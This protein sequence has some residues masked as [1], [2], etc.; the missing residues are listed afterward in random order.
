MKKRAGT[1]LTCLIGA[2]ALQAAEPVATNPV[3][4]HVVLTWE[5]FKNITDW[6]AHQPDSNANGEFTIPWSEAK[7]LFGIEVENMDAAELTLPWKEFKALLEW[8]VR[9]EERKQQEA[10]NTLPAPT[11]YLITSAE[12]TG[13]ELSDEGAFFEATLKIDILQEDRW[14]KIHV[15]PGNVAISKAELPEG[16]FLQQEGNNYYLLTQATG[17][18]EARFEFTA[19]VSESGGSHSLSFNKVSSGT[20]LV[21]VTVPEKDVDIKIRGAQSKLSKSAGEATRSVAALPANASVYIS[22]ERAIPEADQVPPKLYAETRTLISVNDGMLL[23]RSQLAFNVLHAGTRQIELNIPKGA[24]VYDVRGPSIRDWRID[25]NDLQ[26]HFSREM[27]GSFSVEVLYEAP[28]GTDGAALPVITADGVEREKGHIAIV[29]LS[30][31]EISGLETSGATEVDTKDLPPELLGMT[32]QPVLLGYRYVDPR[33]NVSLK[34]DKHPDV[35]VLL[36][37]VDSAN[38][39]VMQTLDGRRIVKARYNVRNNRNQFLRLKLP[40]GAALWSA[41]VAG[42]TTPPAKDEEGRLLLPLV[43]SQGVGGLSS[44]P[45]EITYAENDQAPDN[46]GRGT[47][48]VA[49]VACEEPVLHMMLELYVPE[50]GRYSDFEGNLREVELFTPIGN[51]ALQLNVA[52]IQRYPQDFDAEVGQRTQAIVRPATDDAVKVQ[53]PVTGELYRFEKI[54]VL[55][56]QPWI[57]YSYT[58]LK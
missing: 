54:L 38:F 1:L 51:E 37:V 31:V 39:T 44:F 57:S 34:I 20:C 14:Q 45:V 3:G 36:T 58:G 6:D 50:E 56:E 8:S 46:R 13:K 22:W 18:I 42:K 26:L 2:S 48:K 49:L 47:A 16:V 25:G 43:R 55:D 5:E 19:Q 33:F 32:S 4:N 21:D 10:N 12:Y 30:N 15:L 29:A 35:D 11:P 52:S 53:L 9:E 28:V 27:I 17:T 23:G 24:S 40:E 41:S 7:D